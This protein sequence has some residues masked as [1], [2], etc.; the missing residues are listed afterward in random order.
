VKTIRRVGSSFTPSIK[1][2]LAGK[3]I[4]KSIIDEIAET[5][6]NEYENFA[7]EFTSEQLAVKWNEFLGL[8]SD[9]PN[10]ISTL[11]NVP[12]LTNGNKLLLKIGNSVQEEDVRQIKPELINF[13]RKEL[14]NSG[15]E[16]TTSIE[17]IESERTHFNDSEKM[18]LLMQK[19][20]ELFELK[21]KF[22]LDFN[23]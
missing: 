16:M 4:E 13:L 1:D 5:T 20:P 11:S 18:Q 12:E 6:Y 8:I 19:N 9:R 15:I 22:N 3:V 10:L 23:A 14:R 21:Q 17:K 2:A 7:D